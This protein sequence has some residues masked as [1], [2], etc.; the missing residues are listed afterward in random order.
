M[1]TNLW[2]AFSAL[3]P[4]SPL[5]IGTVQSIDVDLG[6]SFVELPGGG[7]LTVRGTNVEVGK[8]AFVRAGLIEG[9]APDLEVVEIEI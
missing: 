9:Q 8:K 5:L 7:L 1:R 2:G 4:K 3:L 6:T